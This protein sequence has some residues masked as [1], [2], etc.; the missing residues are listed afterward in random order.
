VA[1]LGK[2]FGINLEKN[3]TKNGSEKDMKLERTDTEIPKRLL[4]TESSGYLTIQTIKISTFSP[5][6][7]PGIL[8]FRVR[9][10]KNKK[11]TRK[12]GIKFFFF[13]VL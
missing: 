1:V 10:E 13:H 8:T 2:E 7:I 4:R 5:N 11:Q 6:G 12:L 9:E 3:S